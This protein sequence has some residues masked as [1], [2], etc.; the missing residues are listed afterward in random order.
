MSKEDNQL[1]WGEWDSA[2]IFDPTTTEN[3]SNEWDTV[4][5]PNINEDNKEIQ[6]DNEPTWG[7][8]SLND[9]NETNTLEWE[10][11]TNNPPEPDVFDN[12]GLDSSFNFL[13]NTNELYFQG[14][15][16]DTTLDNVKMVEEINGLI[17]PTDE[18]GRYSYNPSKDSV[19]GELVHNLVKIG[20]RQDTRIVDSSV[21]K[22]QSNESFLNIF[23]GKPTFNFIYFAQSN[24]TSGD[25]ILDFSSMGGP[26]YKINKPKNGQLLVIPGW[27][28]YRISKN[29]TEKDN[30][31]IT[32]MYS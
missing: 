10:E 6:S 19:L 20:I 24:E 17:E 1:K 25:I 12:Y 28:P 5:K 29:K 8:D 26:S 13:G 32:G 9:N 16:F 14:Y 15:L 7:G 27:I 23:K 22:T 21:V 4:T 30:I 11:S 18:E 3:K 2:P 31:L